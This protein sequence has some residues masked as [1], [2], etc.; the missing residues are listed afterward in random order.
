MKIYMKN[1]K[2]KVEFGG[3]QQWASK[4]FRFRKMDL[5]DTNFI[6]ERSKNEML[7]KNYRKWPKTFSIVFTK[8]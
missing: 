6:M 7:S 1:E 5:F 8:N 2:Q 3:K 4:F